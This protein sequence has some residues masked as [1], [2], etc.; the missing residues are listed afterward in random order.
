MAMAKLGRK[1]LLRRKLK[2]Q[3][4]SMARAGVPI[5]IAVEGAGISRAQ[6]YVWLKKGADGEEPYA[7]F[8]ADLRTAQATARA[9]MV[10]Q[11][12]KHGAKY[13]Q[14]PA[15][16]LEHTDQENFG[17]KNQ[18]KVQL[19]T[20]VNNLLSMAQEVCC[21]DCFAKLLRKLSGDS[22]VTIG[23]GEIGAGAP[24]LGT[25][26]GVGATQLSEDQ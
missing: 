17:I 9:Q 6:F 14:A 2:E 22:I 19:E 24:S 3:L 21:A 18:V 1:P 26:T 25:G 16:I 8:L 15:W 12:R 5:K 4:L 20:E 10:L 7:E 11:I 23:T 13:W